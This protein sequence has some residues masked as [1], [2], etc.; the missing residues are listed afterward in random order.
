VIPASTSSNCA[1][2]NVCEQEQ[3][4]LNDAQDLWAPSLFTVAMFYSKSICNKTKKLSV[5]WNE[6]Q[7]RDI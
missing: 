4:M 5:I 7:L 1:L 2:F 6:V 3:I